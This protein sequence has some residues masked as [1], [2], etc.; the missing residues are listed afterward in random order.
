MVVYKTGRV[1]VNPTPFYLPHC[2]D[3]VI[4]GVFS[5]EAASGFGNTILVTMSAICA[6]S[7]LIFCRI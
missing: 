4:V 6:K 3:A 5:L 7:I 1:L 2:P